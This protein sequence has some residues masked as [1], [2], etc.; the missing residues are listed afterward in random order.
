[1]IAVP[2]FEGE[3]VAVFGL[4]RT[5]LSAA[6]ALMAGGAK[7]VAWDD[8]EKGRAAAE[9]A[10]LPLADAAEWDWNAIK[11]LVLSPGVP[12]THPKP[13]PIVEA[14]QAH[15][16][17][18]VSDIEL[19]CRTLKARGALLG[20]GGSVNPNSALSANAGGK[21]PLICVTGTNGKSTTTALIGHLLSKNGF[22]A[23]VG[24][25][26]GK[27]V[28][29]LK[30]PRDG[31][32]YVVEI[33]SYQLDI[34]PS[35]K[36]NVAVLLN[37]TPDHLDRHGGMEGYVAAKRRIFARQ[38]ASDLAVVGVDTAPS[39]ETC[40]L[41]SGRGG[42]AVAPVSVGR[43]IGRGV[44]VLN[45]ALYDGMF[46]PPAEIADLKASLRCP[47]RITGRTPPPP[48]PRFARS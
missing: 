28:L 1:M 18:I 34:T 20:N 32:A 5:G 7:V 37:V 6:R 2:L 8:G 10:A 31:V 47:A 29:E 25:N 43:V 9:A 16:V 30:P 22:D 27:P 36:P 13:H 19:F 35:L 45:G 15:G 33:S 41:I 23:Q 48:M 38:T 44:F 21:T 26:I 24:G 17:E 11:A 40:T 39:A 4:A 42:P 14:A 12:F 46:S 3:T